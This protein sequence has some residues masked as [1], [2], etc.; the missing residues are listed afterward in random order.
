MRV[1]ETTDIGFGSCPGILVPPP[2]PP[3]IDTRR[4]RC[5]KYDTYAA[6]VGL[7]RLNGANVPAG[8]VDQLEAGLADGHFAVRVLLTSR[9]PG[10]ASMTAYDFIM[11]RESNRWNLIKKV[12]IYDMH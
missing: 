6:A 9:S 2:P 8:G 10:G 11:V 12:G 3:E 7:P 1:A 5:P 4:E